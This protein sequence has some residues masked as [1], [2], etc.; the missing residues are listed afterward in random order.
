MIEYILVVTVTV[1]IVT[2][3]AQRMY[4]PLG[5]FVE[6]LMGTYVACLLETGELPALGSPDGNSECRPPLMGG[7]P[8]PDVADGSQSQPKSDSSKNTGED[9]DSS[10]K[11]K[12]PRSTNDNPSASNNAGAGSRTIIRGQGASAGVDGAVPGRRVE[13]SLDGGGGGAFF[14]SGGGGGGSIY[15]RN[16]RYL[17]VTGGLA[18]EVKKRQERESSKVSSQRVEGDARGANKKIEVKQP[19]RKPAEDKEM[20]GLDI[21]EIIKYIL[22]AGI[23]II[24]L[25]LIGG[26]ALQLSKS[27][28]KGE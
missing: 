12:D 8:G 4:K 17:A 14:G 18:E 10:D 9:P 20:G 15:Q 25:V 23:I 19:E 11:V 5:D 22:I 21:S 7:E 26:Q 6:G 2:A 27:W 13:I 1:I 24:L 16:S 28:E 3:M